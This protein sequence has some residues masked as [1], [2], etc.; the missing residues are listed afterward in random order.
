M[1]CVRPRAWGE[2]G[3]SMM[4]AVGVRWAPSLSRQQTLEARRSAHPG[5]AES[6]G[7]AA[8][9]YP[10]LAGPERR[11]SRL[12]PTKV[13]AGMSCSVPKPPWGPLAGHA[14]WFLICI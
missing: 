12:W 8:F 4:G 1:S 11:A 5:P 9:L 3:V 13:G 14:A 10:A 2:A 7:A 6:H